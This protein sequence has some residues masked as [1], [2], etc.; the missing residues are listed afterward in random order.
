MPTFSF[1]AAVL[2]GFACCWAA[3]SL[4]AVRAADD[5]ATPPSTPTRR[6]AEKPPKAKPAPIADAREMLELY[7]VDNSYLDGLVDGQAIGPDEQES[8]WRVLFAVRR[9]SVANIYRWSNPQ[10]ALAQLPKTPGEFRG[11]IFEFS[12]RVKNVT[13]EKPLAEVVDRFNL[14]QFYRCELEFGDDRR[15]ATVYALAVPKAWKKDRPL[16][17]RCGVR[18]FFLKLGEEDRD[19][20]PRLVF[21]AQRVAWYPDTELGDLKMDV[22]LFDEL[23]PK[24]ELGAEDRECFY[25]L[26]AAAGRAGTQELLRRTP[27]PS[28]VAPLFNQP[29]TQQGKLVALVGTARQALLRRV[30]DPDIV[31]RF[32]IDHYYEIEISTPDSQNNP[33]TF[34][35]RQLPEGFPQ[36][37]R[38][39]ET[40]RIPGFFMKK[41]GYR[42][43]APLPPTAAGSADLGEDVVRRQLAPLLIG[44]EP[45]WIPGEKPDTGWAT[46]TFV[47]AFVVGMLLLWLVVWRLNRSDDRFHRQVVRKAVAIEDGRSL[48]DLGL[49]DAG[50]PR[51]D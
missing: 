8:L 11:E 48:N 15:P 23:S 27:Q 4:T 47:A 49:E 26:L 25:E 1:K 6:P 16:D 44:R 46:T 34:C 20:R 21:A 50:P 43:D 37:E 45:L 17:E 39:L 32:G 7:G 28:P 3:V 22:G 18:G 12:G 51:F 30:E 2:A 41:W 38:I 14:P 33:I 10:A 40:V 9:F 5:K 42:V 24:A 13:I 35:V 19:G 36:G 31:S 29:Q